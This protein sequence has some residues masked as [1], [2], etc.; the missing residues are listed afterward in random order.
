MQKEIQTI[1]LI[2]KAILILFI[3]GTSFIL[4]KATHGGAKAHL[5]TEIKIEL[6][7]KL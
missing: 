2:K 5:T 1:S 7:K 6:S 3:V 4:M